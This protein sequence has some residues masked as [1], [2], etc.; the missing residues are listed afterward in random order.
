MVTT[1]SVYQNIFNVKNSFLNLYRTGFR[2]SAFPEKLCALARQ[3]PRI[4]LQSR[5]KI[6]G[7]PFGRSAWVR[8]QNHSVRLRCVYF[9]KSEPISKV[10]GDVTM[11]SATAQHPLQNTAGGSVLS[12][13]LFRSVLALHPAPML[14][15]FCAVWVFL[16]SVWAWC[17]EG[18][19]SP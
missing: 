19:V 15:L 5:Q 7:T 16:F 10:S 14:N 17:G 11:N 9:T 4:L 2:T 13:L 12:L 8:I 6:L 3:N 18:R 1:K